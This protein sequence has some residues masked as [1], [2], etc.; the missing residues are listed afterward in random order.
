MAHAI[1][2]TRLLLDPLGEPVPAGV[3]AATVRVVAAV[4]ADA[5]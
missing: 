5:A 1:V 3:C 4:L 2:V